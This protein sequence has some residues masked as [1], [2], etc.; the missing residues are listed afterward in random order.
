MRRTIRLNDDWIIDFP[1]SAGLDSE[2]LCTVAARLKEI[3]A[4]VHAV[5]IV[6]HG[7]LVFEQ[8]CGL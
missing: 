3:Q 7:K 4:N 2:R 8:Y 1:D 6:R 5:V